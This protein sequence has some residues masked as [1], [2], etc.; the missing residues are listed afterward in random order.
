MTDT[1]VFEGAE[2]ISSRRAAQLTGYAQDYIGQLARAGKIDA[3][4]IGG[5]WYVGKDSI[6]K[7]HAGEIERD[8]VLQSRPQVRFEKPQVESVVSFEGRSYIS[9]NRAAE[10]CGYN[11]DYVGQLARSGTIMARQIGTRWYVDLEQLRAHKAEKDAL[12]ARV[13]AESVGL[14]RT[15]QPSTGGDPIGSAIPA[16]GVH[17]SY[18]TVEHVALPIL[19]KVKGGEITR[20]NK[21]Y[22]E[23]EL[24]QRIP[25]RVLHRSV[26]GGDTVPLV[27]VERGGDAAARTIRKKGLGW[28]LAGSLSALVI[29]VYVALVAFPQNPTFAVRVSGVMQQAS[30]VSA[31]L[32]ESVAAERVR[33]YFSKSLEYR[34]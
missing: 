14:V 16:G 25:I 12:L 24:I 2:Y 34:R 13:Q 11:P 28:V 31:V 3:R 19:N 29:T 8:R 21:P 5:L 1:V 22:V 6:E 26:A 23:D 9:A 17:Y 10:L 4:R 18:H 20:E 7:H 30:V 27:A 33:Q 15:M 32:S